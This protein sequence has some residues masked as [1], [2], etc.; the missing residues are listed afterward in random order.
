MDCH[1]FRRLCDELAPALMGCRVEK[2]HQPASDVT[3]LTLYGASKGYLFLKAGRKAPFLFLSQHKIA[4]G[5]A[6]PASTMRL[7]KYLSDRRI[8]DV[9]VDWVER[10]LFLSISPECHL[11]LDLRDGPSLLFAPL[12]TVEPPRWPDPAHWREDCADNGWRNW[13]VLTPP[14]RRTLSLLPQ[15]EQAALLLDL[16]A[17]GGD[18]F[19]YESVSAENPTA[20]PERELSAWPLP[21]PHPAS[22][23]S[24]KVTERVLEDALAACALMGETQVLRGMATQSRAQAAKPHQTEAARLGRLLLKLETERDRLTRMVEGQDSACALQARLYLFDPDEKR[25]TVVLDPLGAEEPPRTLRLNPRLTIRENMA[26]L[27]HTAGRGKRGLEHLE[28]RFASVRDERAQA[29]QAALFAQAMS[30]AS[31]ASAPVAP[32][33]TRTSRTSELPKNVQPFRSSDGFLILRG[34]DAKG[35]AQLLKLASPNDLWM[36]TGGGP[37]AHV[38]IRR[39]HAA[40][41]IPVA[42]RTEAAILAVLKS[43][44]KDEVQVDVI[45][46]F[47]KYVHPIRGARPGTVRIDRAEP[48]IIVTPDPSLEERLGG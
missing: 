9:L 28:K 30:S 31:P 15:D 12:P 27:F 4:V 20:P 37:G 40:Q 11:C 33:Q 29:E 13:P 36:H 43:W 10:R 45:A 34:R 5:S 14:L 42:T 41:E 2:I 3:M 39:D 26:A 6:P 19:L 22:L 35:N 38:L 8:V 7:R 24:P 46:A 47:A 16:E 48:A 32:V 44:R 1:V 18:L 23:V 21:S 17:G 25:A